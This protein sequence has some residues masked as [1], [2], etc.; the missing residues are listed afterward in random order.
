MI[1]RRESRNRVGVVWLDSEDAATEFERQMFATYPASSIEAAN[2]GIV[3]VGRD[4]AFDQ[5]GEFA[6]VT[7]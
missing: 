1:V 2:L 3:Q 6:V 5:P 7:P 4:K